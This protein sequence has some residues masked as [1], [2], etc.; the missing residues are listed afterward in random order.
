MDLSP[1]A[2]FDTATANQIRHAGA[3]TPANCRVD[4]TPAAGAN[5]PPV[6]TLTATAA[7]C[8]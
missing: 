7:N 2:D 1:A 8:G 3:A 6:Y 4:Y 5:T